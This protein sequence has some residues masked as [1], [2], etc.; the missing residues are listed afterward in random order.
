MKDEKEGDIWIIREK[1]T[2]MRIINK[3]KEGLL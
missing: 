1:D 3:E 2:E